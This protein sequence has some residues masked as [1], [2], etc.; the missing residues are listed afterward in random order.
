MFYSIYRSTVRNMVRSVTFWLCVSILLVVTVE[1]GLRTVYGVF[2]PD[3]GEMI[4]DSDPRYVLEHMPYIQQVNNSISRLMV[5]ILPC[6]YVITTVIILARDLGDGFFEIEKAGGVKPLRYLAARITA[7]FSINAIVSLIAGVISL[8]I[9][10]LTRGGVSG[11]AFWEYFADG[12]FR[13]IRSGIIRILPC[14]A[15]YICLTYCL[16]SLT[17]SRIAASVGG[18]SYMLFCYFNNLFNVTKEGLF[19]EYLT[20]NPF[21]LQM[22]MH[23]FGTDSHEDLIEIMNT[24]AWDALLCILFLCGCGGIFSLISWWNIRKRTV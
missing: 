21:K 9:Y 20:P 11:M 6:F 12:T 8:Q 23:Y 15:F 10:V 4:W 22:Y 1:T 16:G 3:L 14:M 2:D 7:L 19:V 13:V 18:L 17:K 24:S 5:Y